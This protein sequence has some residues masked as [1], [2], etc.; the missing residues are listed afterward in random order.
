MAAARTT[1]GFLVATL[2]WLASSMG[3]DA[4]DATDPVSSANSGAKP[5][6]KRDDKPEDKSETAPKSDFCVTLLTTFTTKDNQYYYVLLDP[7][8]LIDENYNTN[9]DPYLKAFRTEI[10][11]TPGFDPSANVGLIPRVIKSEDELKTA[12]GNIKG[13]P[14]ELVLN[15][16]K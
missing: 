2:P 7:C 1:L 10:A 5:D 14:K 15:V 9:I 13:E 16:G 12:I 6:A 3:C 8:V 11:K 4:S